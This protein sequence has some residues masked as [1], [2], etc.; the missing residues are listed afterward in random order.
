MGSRPAWCTKHSLGASD[1]RDTFAL[2]T[3]IGT[4]ASGTGG[5]GLCRSASPRVP[6]SRQ[7]GPGVQSGA[8]DRLPG[9]RRRRSS[10][11]GRILRH[12]GNYLRCAGA[13]LRRPRRQLQCVR[14]LGLRGL[15]N[16]DHLRRMRASMACRSPT[17]PAW[18]GG[19][20]AMPPRGAKAVVDGPVASQTAGTGASRSCLRPLPPGAHPSRILQRPSP[21]RRA[22]VGGAVR[23][24]VGRVRCDGN[25]QAR[26]AGADDDFSAAGADSSRAVGRVAATQSQV[27]LTAGE[28]QT[29]SAVAA[30]A[31]RLTAGR[32]APGDRQSRK[33]AESQ[34][35]FVRLALPQHHGARR[36]HARRRRHMATSRQSPDRVSG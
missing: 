33:S 34:R 4:P 22:T 25:P 7:L 13:S 29:D 20:S 23:G 27:G 3:G 17:V 5:G 16:A 28:G 11:A 26:S 35:E 10:G 14:R 12:P 32:S 21:G 31:D 24:V 9:S 15:R 2:A 6:P 8:V 30:A 19:M 18:H 1:E 36:S